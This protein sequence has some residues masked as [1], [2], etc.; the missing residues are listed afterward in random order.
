MKWNN[1]NLACLKTWV[2]LRVLDQHNE[3]F[4]DAEKI[5]MDQLTFWNNA[6][7]NEAREISAKTL[8][9][10]LDNMFRLWDKADY[11]N[12]SSAKEAVEAMLKVFLNGKKTLND[13]AQA[14]DDN[15]KFKGE[16][17]DEA[18]L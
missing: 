8:C 2:H 18:L 6:S 3:A 15:Y 4:R 13:L 1:N 16:K 10:Q 12:S 11:E 9:N 14:V 17:P 5:R 7:S